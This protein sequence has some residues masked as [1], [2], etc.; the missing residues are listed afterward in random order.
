M[1]Y[2]IAGPILCV[3]FLPSCFLPPRPDDAPAVRYPS[4][5]PPLIAGACEGIAGTY[6]YRGEAAPPDDLHMPAV[7]IPLFVSTTAPVDVT[8]VSLAYNAAQSELTLTHG[9]DT[10]AVP[11]TCVNGSL[12]IRQEKSYG[13]EGYSHE[14]LKLSTLSNNQAQE[15]VIHTIDSDNY[16]AFCVLGFTNSSR[17][18]HWFRFKRAR[19]F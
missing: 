18:E 1:T 16:C 7:T 2:R 15:L 4:A 6:E 19:P 5:W 11:A 10:A 17:S 9:P 3:A 12:I 13:V 8:S 14:T